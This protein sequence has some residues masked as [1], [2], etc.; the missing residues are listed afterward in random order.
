MTNFITYLLIYLYQKKATINQLNDTAGRQ[1]AL[2]L[3]KTHQINRQRAA[4]FRSAKDDLQQ[5][6]NIK[7]PT[8]VPPITTCVSKANASPGLSALRNNALSTMAVSSIGSSSLN[9]ERLTNQGQ[10]QSVDIQSN[11]TTLGSRWHNSD[12]SLYQSSITT[13]YPNSRESTIGPTGLPNRQYANQLS[14]LNKEHLTNDSGRSTASSMSSMYPT[15][16][17]YPNES[18][19]INFGG[20]SSPSLVSSIMPSVMNTEGRSTVYLQNKL[21][22]KQTREISVGA[23]LNP[24]S[25]PS[26]SLK[27]DCVTTERSN[28]QNKHCPNQI[29][30]NDNINRTNPSLATSTVS[31]GLNNSTNEITKLQNKLYQNECCRP[32]IQ[33]SASSDSSSLQSNPLSR[34]QSNISLAP[35]SS[36]PVLKKGHIMPERTDL[37]NKNQSRAIHFGGQSSLA[38]SIGSVHPGQSTKFLASS[39]NVNNR[40][41]TTGRADSNQENRSVNKNI[42]ESMMKTI[43]PNVCP[44]KVSDGWSYFFVFR[45]V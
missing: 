7:K 29:R 6:S 19:A 37:Q 39:C 1:P 30:T 41:A 4:Q 22:L 16:G 5:Y 43:T 15:K 32:L 34:G 20:Q 2:M 21:N 17:Q 8:Y 12:S 44:T 11:T 35:S 10:P 36:V 3:E 13:S 28:I 40:Q 24:S 14:G 27:K 23:Q 31:S 9:R 25:V 26:A 33:Y 38:P 45:I 42:S 18:Q